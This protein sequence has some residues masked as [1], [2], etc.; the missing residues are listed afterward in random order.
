MTEDQRIKVSCHVGYVTWAV[1][2]LVSLLFPP[3]DPLLSLIGQGLIAGM[4]ATGVLGFVLSHPQL[5]QR[6][7]RLDVAEWE[8]RPAKLARDRTGA[9]AGR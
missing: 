3:H 8:A 1:Y 7:S 5:V 9:P 4:A 2:V 6:R